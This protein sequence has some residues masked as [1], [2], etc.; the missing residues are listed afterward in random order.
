MSFKQCK[1][2]ILMRLFL[3][4]LIIFL[5]A[6]SITIAHQTD[7]LLGHYEPHIDYVVTPGD[8][9][10][11]WQ[12]SISYDEDNDFLDQDGIV[13]LDPGQTR[14]VVGP[15]SFI[16]NLPS[17]LGTLASAGDPLW[18]LPQ[19]NLK[20]QLFLGLRTVI[21]AG[22][23]QF[24][25]N[26]NFV[27]YGQGNIILEMVALSGPAVDA[28]GH[29]AMWTVGSL[30]NSEFHFDSSDGIDSGDRLEP[31]PIGSHSHYNWGMTQPG[32]YEV[33][34]RASGRLNPPYGGIDTSATE[35]FTFSVPFSS[36]AVGEAT[37][38]LGVGP[39]AVAPASV[40]VP[41][42]GVEYAPGQVALQ[43]TSQEVEAI[44]RPYACLLTVETAA[45]THAPHR[46]GI[47]GAQPVRFE[48]GAPAA[49]PLEVLSVRGPGTLSRVITTE[50]DHGF[51]FSEAGVYR[52]R[53]R[54]A[55][56]GGSFGQP[57]EL[58]FLAGLS[59]DYSF[60]EWADSYE[61]T[62][63]L[64]SGSFNE[65]GDWDGDGVPDLIEYQLFWE[66]FDP[67][68]AD[69]HRVPRLDHNNLQEFAVFHRD[70]YKDQLNRDLENI[71]MEFSE[72]LVS[73][74]GWRDGLPGQPLQ[75]FENGA[76]QGNAHGR[77]MRR[78][79]RLPQSASSAPSK[80]FLR[81]RIDLA[82]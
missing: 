74:T 10:A 81:W 25:F 8:P 55:V 28:G 7:L 22:I 42:E 54:A 9:D 20:G 70:T 13:R 64:P 82:K 30:G 31:V 40:Y 43:A 65:N 38:R 48:S 59:P 35:T 41:S 39:G 67:A 18:I 66:G 45:A 61:R 56:T 4:S 68:V 5:A 60:A 36:V 69:A 29:F 62:H 53:L 44:Q 14:I 47:P 50:G 49:D 58:V 80:G 51:I 37:L 71:V 33:T 34:F 73:W 57:F 16:A 21:P 2:Y 79:L 17:N 11:G 12:F 32:L 26:G 23:F 15:E 1:E 76:E 63:G 19:G 52:V 78:A 46:V 24:S 27:P 77:I 6:H 75:Q 3:F 72:D